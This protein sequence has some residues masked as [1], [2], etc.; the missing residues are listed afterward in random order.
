MLGIYNTYG[1]A[2]FANPLLRQ[3]SERIAALIPKNLSPEFLS[4][5]F[6]ED[7]VPIEGGV[8][9]EGQRTGGPDFTDPRQAY[10]QTQLANG[11]AMDVVLP[12]EMVDEIDPYKHLSSSF[13]P[14]FIAHGDMDTMVPL[15]ISQDLYLEMRKHGIRCKLQIIPGEDH[16]FTARMKVG[17]QTWNLQREGFDFLEALIKAK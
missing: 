10:V 15:Q 5:V 1:V 17:S 9:L 11:T 7:P 16:M 6:H 12:E 2:N 13:P 3:K 14:T 8:S 4:R